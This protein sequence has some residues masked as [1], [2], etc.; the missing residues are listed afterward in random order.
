MG[1]WKGA[2]VEVREMKQE[3]KLKRT[4]RNKGEIK[5]RKKDAMKE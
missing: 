1:G 2:R 4:G 5:W 3:K